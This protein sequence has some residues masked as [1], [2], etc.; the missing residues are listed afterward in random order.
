[1]PS[2]VKFMKEILSKKRKMETMALTEEYS[3]ILQSIMPQKLRDPGS[4]T[5]PYIIEN[6]ECKHALCDLE[7]NINLMPLYV[8]HR[9]GL[10]EARPTTIVV[11]L[12][13]RSVKHPRVIIEDVL[14]K[15]DKFI[16]LADFIV[17]DMEED[18][19]Y[20]TWKTILSH[21]TSTD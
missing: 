14:M 21:G 8:F 5:I 9:P 16:F 4:F 19:T 11:H 20:H 2:Y 1:M 13:D 7:T 17:L 3:E 10:G 6:F 12:A 15:L 18:A